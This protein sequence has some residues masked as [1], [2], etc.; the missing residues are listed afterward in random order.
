MFV[1]QDMQEL[2]E[3]FGKEGTGASNSTLK[4]REISPGRYVAIATA[5]NRTLNAGALIDIRLGTVQNDNGVVSAPLDQS[6]AKAT[7]KQLTPDVPMENTPSASTV[8]RYYDAFPLNAKDKPDLLVSWADGPVES[9][10]LAAAG[11]SANF[12]VYLYDSAHQ[13]RHPILDDP[14]MWDIFARPLQTRTAPNIVGSA[15]DPKLAGQTLIGK[16][17]R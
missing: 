4:A 3:G 1:N 2:R 8:G 17:R 11:L 15:Q 7:Y 12:G 14:N 9:G 10:V 6:E 16:R 13:Q 5:R